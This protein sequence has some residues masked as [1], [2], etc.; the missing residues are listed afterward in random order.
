M[1]SQRV[2]HDEQL[3]TAQ[4]FCAVSFNLGFVFVCVWWWGRGVGV[5][6]V[7]VDVGKRQREPASQKREERMRESMYLDKDFRLGQPELS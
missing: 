5:G 3:S 7:A 2:R 4:H 1:G 6:V